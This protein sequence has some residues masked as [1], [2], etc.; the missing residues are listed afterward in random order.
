MSTYT[1]H[2][3]CILCGKVLTAL[4][5]KQGTFSYP[6]DWCSTSH[7]TNTYLLRLNERNANKGDVADNTKKKL[8][9]LQRGH[10]RLAYRNG[11]RA[12]IRVFSKMSSKETN[13]SGV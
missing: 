13:T 2:V 9:R 3:L 7:N 8:K 12:A 4:S 11:R 10:S 1:E 6:E 5:I